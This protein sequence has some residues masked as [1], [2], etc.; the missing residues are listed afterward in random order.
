MKIEKELQ[1]DHQ[2]KLNVELDADPFEKAKRQAAR[3]I[4]KKVKIPGFRPGKAPYNVIL[5]QVGEGA[6]VEEA[7]DILIEDIYPKV[8]EEA[9]ITPYG[10]G[11][12]EKVESLDPP[13][14]QFVVPLAPE[15]E[16]G[17]YKE[18]EIDYKVPEVEAA[19]IDA[20]IEQMLQQQAI[21]EQS[22]EP[23]KE[24]D[25]VFYQVSAD[26]AEI[27]DGEEANI[28]P[29]RF[30]STIIEP[31]SEAQNHWPYPGFSQNL[32]GLSI[33]GEKDVVYTYPEDHEDEDLQG[34]EA[35]F[36]ITVT[37]IQTVSLPELDDEFAKSAS[38]FETIEELRA[39]IE[40]KLKEA[41]RTGIRT[42][43]TMIRSSKP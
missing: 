25:R 6:V 15:V 29:E 35:I 14:F 21:T 17:D 22:E 12:L 39:D 11:N 43:P 38:D 8:L 42:R 1:E 9:E 36:H 24:G 7:M 16:L 32:I 33:D 5:R 3:K 31:E 30:N 34:V 26:R 37:N 10:P 27:E 20:Q 4:A 2:I 40:E 13:T 28:I 19:A 41:A 23:A 18:L